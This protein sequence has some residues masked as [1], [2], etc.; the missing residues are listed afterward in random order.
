MVAVGPDRAVRA[1]LEQPPFAD[2]ASRRSGFDQPK[3]PAMAATCAPRGA[4]RIC[5]FD[6][7][8]ADHLV[9]QG[10]GECGGDGFAS[11]AAF[12]VAGDAP[13]INAYIAIGLAHR[14]EQ[15]VLLGAGRHGALSLSVSS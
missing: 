6:H 12:A 3:H 11:W 9:D 7:A 8:F 15:F 13:S 2:P 14:F 4:Q 1:R 5:C 10:F